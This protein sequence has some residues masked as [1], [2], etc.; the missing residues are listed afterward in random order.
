MYLLPVR[1]TFQ[2]R[3]LKNYLKT[4]KVRIIEFFDK[5]ICIEKYFCIY[6]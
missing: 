4:I 3:M 2:Q 5:Y 6:N 1:N